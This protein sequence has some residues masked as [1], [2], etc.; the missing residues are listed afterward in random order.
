[1]LNKNLKAIIELSLAGASVFV[2]GCRP[3]LPNYEFRRHTITTIVANKTNVVEI[4]GGYGDGK[5]IWQHTN[6][7]PEVTFPRST[8]ENKKLMMPSF[9]KPRDHYNL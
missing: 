8:R 1:M 9:Y 4:I 6:D 5:L 3:N 7:N 2:A